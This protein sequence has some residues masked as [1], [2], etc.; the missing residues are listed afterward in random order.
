VAGLIIRANA[1]L[2]QLD[3]IA[4]TIARNYNPK[5]TNKKILVHKATLIILQR[6][7]LGRTQHLQDVVSQ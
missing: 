1:R 2:G 4:R 7:F 5:M 3:P 6:R